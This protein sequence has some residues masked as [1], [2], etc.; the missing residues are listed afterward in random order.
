MG[1]QSSQP[2]D[3]SRASI[4]IPSQR[5]KLKFVGSRKSIQQNERI[6]W[7][8]RFCCS[9]TSTGKVWSIPILKIYF[10]RKQYGR[11]KLSNN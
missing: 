9:D 11:K 2:D 4:K 7:I 1:Q 5:N 3:E 8:S 6:P 10:S